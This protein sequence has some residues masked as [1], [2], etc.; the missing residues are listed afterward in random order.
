MLRRST[1]AT[2][3]GLSA[4]LW[5]IGSANAAVYCAH[6]IG[7][8]ERVS[9]GSPRSQCDFAT[10]KECRASVRER[11]GGTCYRQGHLARSLGR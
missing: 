5:T 4:I 9:P 1:T 10:L 6:Y 11:G 8:P 3:L 7:G 2:V